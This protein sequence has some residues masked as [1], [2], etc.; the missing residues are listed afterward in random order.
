MIRV[1]IYRPDEVAEEAKCSICQQPIKGAG[2]MLYIPF[3]GII[4]LHQD[5]CLAL[6]ITGSGADHSLA[7]SPEKPRQTSEA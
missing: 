3:G 4:Q 7:I 6:W 5:A 1:T 2:I